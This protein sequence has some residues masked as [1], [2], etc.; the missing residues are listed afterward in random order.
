M[1]FIQ[2][3]VSVVFY[4]GMFVLVEINGTIHLLALSEIVVLSLGD[5][6]KL[7][8]HGYVVVCIDEWIIPFQG[9]RGLVLGVDSDL[10]YHAVF[11]VGSCIVD[12]QVDQPTE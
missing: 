9:E 2:V 6:E 7:V 10:S 3:E 11:Q 12:Q 8:V 1:S 4:L 5:V